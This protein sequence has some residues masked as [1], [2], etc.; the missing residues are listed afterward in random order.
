MVSGTILQGKISEGSQVEILPLGER[1]K[2][3]SLESHHRRIK[4]G[5]PGQ[6]IGINL[7][8]IGYSHIT[9]GMQ[10]VSPGAVGLW[11]YVNT[12][13]SNLSLPE[14]E[15]KD[16]QK[17]KVYIG[18][19]CF[20]GEVVLFEGQRLFPG[21]K[22][23]AQIRLEQ[24]VGIMPGDRF[25]ITPMNLQRL[26]GG[27][28]VI[29]VTQ[30]KLKTSNRRSHFELIE[31]LRSGRLEDFI[32]EF[33]RQHRVIVKKRITQSFYLDKKAFSNA[34]ERLILSGILT[35]IVPDKLIQ[36]SFKEELKAKIFEIVNSTL[37]QNPI[38]ICVKKQEI[39]ERLGIIYGKTFLDLGEE[40]VEQLLK[41]LV[42][43]G[44]LD[45]EEGGYITSLTDMKLPSEL[46]HLSELI[47]KFS[48]NA[49]LS[50]FSAD[51][52]WKFHERKVEKNQIKKV[53]NYLRAKKLLVRVN[54]GRFLDIEALEEIKRRIIKVVEQ[55]GIFTI[56]D[57]KSAF[58]YGRTVAV[59]ILEYLDRIGFTQ[60][61][62]EGRII[63]K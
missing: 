32:L 45:I 60:R 43:E 37:S 53:L 54:D 57:C 13:I 59:P 51:T 61:T 58:G 41:E 62:G 14:L 46:T 56:Q 50:P 24:E 33:L 25:I 5:Y 27:G 17:V 1:T 9:R 22:T 6:R 36:V 12:E 19:G 8:R 38:Q 4:E 35:E 16:R 40:V 52:I 7:V 55:K 21:D 23:F 11:R 48:K 49:H 39:T 18:T 29:E 28:S 10:L 47:L 26:L 3:R 42:E 34:I 20:I 2:V 44:S 63:K 30:R 15:L 31:A